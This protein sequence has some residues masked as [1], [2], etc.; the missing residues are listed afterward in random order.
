MWG[1]GEERDKKSKGMET[2]ISMVIVVVVNNGYSRKLVWG[3][4]SETVWIV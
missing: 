4:M 3:A 2:G 1:K